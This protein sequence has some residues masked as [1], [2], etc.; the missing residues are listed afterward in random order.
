MSQQLKNQ[1]EEQLLSKQ[2]EIENDAYL[3][4]KTGEVPPNYQRIQVN[5]FDLDFGNDHFLLIKV[6]FMPLYLYQKKTYE[7]Y[8][9]NKK[10]N[11]LDCLYLCQDNLKYNYLQIRLFNF[12]NDNKENLSIQKIYYNN[13]KS[14]KLVQFGNVNLECY[15]YIEPGIVYILSFSIVFKIDLTRQLVESKQYGD[16]VMQLLRILP[17]T[18]SEN[19]YYFKKYQVK[20]SEVQ[21]SQNKMILFVMTAYVVPIE[22]K[23]RQRK[24]FSNWT[25]LV[26][27]QSYGY[28]LVDWKEQN[29]FKREKI[30]IPYLD[31]KT[32]FDRQTS[33]YD[34]FEQIISYKNKIYIKCFQS[35]EI[36]YC[37]YYIN[38]DKL[39][40]IKNY[41]YSCQLIER[42]YL[43]D[44]KVQQDNQCLSPIIFNNQLTYPCIQNFDRISYS[45]KRGNMLAFY[46]YKEEG[47]NQ[48]Q[49][50]VKQASQ[51]DYEDLLYKNNQCIIFKRGEKLEIQYFKDNKLNTEQYVFRSDVNKEKICLVDYNLK[52]YEQVFVS[53]NEIKENSF[54]LCSVQMQ[55]EGSENDNNSY[56][57]LQKDIIS[58]CKF[59]SD[60]ENNLYLPIIFQSGQDQYF[61]IY[62]ITNRK[63]IE[64]SIHKALKFIQSDNLKETELEIYLN[65][66]QTKEQ[67]QSLVLHLS[68]HVD[69]ENFKLLINM[70]T[71][72][73]SYI[74]DSIACLK[75]LKTLNIFI[76]YNS[77]LGSAGVNNIAKA[78]QSLTQLQNL[79]LSFPSCQ[80]E[81]N[82]LSE[83]G[84]T[85][86]K[87]QN[88]AS[89]QIGFY[90]NSLGQ[91]AVAS[92]F[93]DLNSLKNLH[94]LD[95][96]FQHNKIGSQG[97]F[98]LSQAIKNMTNLTKLALNLNYNY[99]QDQGLV[100][101]AEAINQL[102]KMTKLDIK[103]DYNQITKK[104][105][106]NLNKSVSE[107][108][109]LENLNYSLSGNQVG[110]DGFSSFPLLK[111]NKNIKELCLQFSQIQ[112]LQE[113]VSQLGFL[114]LILSKLKLLNLSFNSNQ[115]KPEVMTE[116]GQQIGKSQSIQIL[117]LDFM[118][119]QLKLES[120]VQ[121]VEAIQGCS[122]LREI[123]FDCYYNDFGNS[124]IGFSQLGKALSS[125]QQLQSISINLNFNFLADKNIL[126]FCY[127]IRNCK[128]LLSITLL[129]QENWIGNSC[130]FNSK[131][132]LR[133]LRRLVLMY[134]CI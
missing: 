88:L 101:V 91:L 33:Y 57:I 20:N 60:S 119:N 107:L 47:K 92:I 66:K 4:I 110:N 77:N 126:D 128:N 49:Y 41:T 22:I 94:T 71:D 105:L 5:N 76:N 6:L 98:S 13:V 27:S 48:A 19:N 32:Q 70:F 42:E 59:H 10:V 102:D 95:I 11:L 103:V 127:E 30:L 80:V 113:D 38:V 100:Y 82:K 50:T 74:S 124:Q 3:K 75:N 72:D 87:C 109:E 114:I 64:K 125:C 35:E 36:T 2:L 123:V 31:C 12:Q 112:I 53:K 25:F 45:C 78:I 79:S 37:D 26:K 132:I 1:F 120:F 51:S 61:G 40:G 84:K 131:I 14:N 28:L 81:E 90:H 9:K 111:A 21:E 23:S 104:G 122:N 108:L 117:K 99:I 55:Q 17:I 121:L 97:C 62:D 86:Q 46:Q 34:H 7:V 133:K 56:I 58:F 130:I 63:I 134:C 65:E 52:N 89:L 44:Y 67:I 43:R 69:L 15:D 8:V 106:I 29:L 115:L 39:K 24:I 93:D 18:Q 85:L 83:L 116:L 73:T 118:N 16:G 54:I 96:T 68:K 129:A